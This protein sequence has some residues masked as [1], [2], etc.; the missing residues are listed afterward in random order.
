[1]ALIDM[2]P[3]WYHVPFTQN[4]KHKSKTAHTHNLD[5]FQS[6]MAKLNTWLQT[7]GISHLNQT[8]LVPSQANDPNYSSQA[9]DRCVH[10]FVLQCLHLENCVLIEF[11]FGWIEFIVLSASAFWRS[12]LYNQW[13]L[14]LLCIRFCTKGSTHRKCVCLEF[15]K[16]NLSLLVPK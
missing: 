14:K 8:W 9:S 5:T 2:Q 4:Y 7:H 10:D 15:W 3:S 16:T 1:M 11:R 12:T 13:G 6:S